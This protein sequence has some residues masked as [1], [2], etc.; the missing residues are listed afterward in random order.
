M[1]AETVLFK[2]CSEPRQHF[3][4][5]NSTLNVGCPNVKSTEIML[6]AAWNMKSTKTDKCAHTNGL[7]EENQD[8]KQWW[9]TQ[10]VTGSDKDDHIIPCV[11]K[12][13]GHLV[14][15]LGMC[16]AVL[17]NIKQQLLWRDV[18]LLNGIS[19]CEEVYQVNQQISFAHPP[20]V[21]KGA[22]GRLTPPSATECWTQI[23]YTLYSLE[24]S[25][26]EHSH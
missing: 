21:L 24:C 19:K 14:E 12:T 15:K 8:L 20:Q 18:L 4:R 26:M 11:N 22:A 3:E 1:L 17:Y 2:C 5:L 9:S 13:D 16:V 10:C 7:W 6:A 25:H 23:T